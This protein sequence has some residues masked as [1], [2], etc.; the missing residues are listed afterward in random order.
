[1]DTISEVWLENTAAFLAWTDSLT[2]QQIA[3]RPAEGKW[4]VLEVLEHLFVA[5][6][7]AARIL[8][9]PSEAS[10]RDFEPLL[11]KMN[12]SLRNLD[13]SYAGGS[14]L[15]PKG[16]FTSYADWKMAFQKNR[17]E[18]LETAQKLGY[19][20][21]CTSFPHPYFGNLSRAEWL[22]FNTIHTDRHLAQM[23][24]YLS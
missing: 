19:Q 10:S 9:G 22:I 24:A 6:K 18:M 3:Q 12:Q 4:S 17:T 5:E 16:R 15:D 11:K 7:G 23:K 14:S 8:Q 1:M 21:V 13:A 2:E 20:A